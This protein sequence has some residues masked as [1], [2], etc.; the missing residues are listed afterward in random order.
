MAEG[1]RS[2][3]SFDPARYG[4]IPV[5]EL[6]RAAAR[7]WVGVDRRLIQSL[8]DRGAG[9]ASETLAFSREPH[10]SDPVGLEP[11]L[12][13]LFRHF[14]EPAALDFFVDAVR[15][16]PEEVGDDLVQA[17]LPF[18]EKALDP[19]LA[20]YDELGEERGGEVAFLLAGLGQRD[21]RVLEVLLERLEYDAADGAFLLG[22]YCDPAARPALEQMLA[23]VPVDA[24]ELRREISYALESIDNQI[25]SHALRYE[26]EPFDILAQYPE[27]DLPE[28]QILTEAE[29]IELLSSPDREIRGGAAYSFFNEE[30]SG[31]AR[32]ALLDI[33]R[34]DPDPEVRG[35]AWESLGDAVGEKSVREQMLAILRD[36]TRPVEERGGAAVGLYGVGGEAEVS[37]LLEALYQE[38]GHARA[39]ALEGMWRSLHKPFARFFP[40]HLNDEDPAIVEQALRGAGYFQ[41]STY[42]DKMASYFDH[43]DLREHA[44]FAYALA[45]PGETSRGRAQGMLRKIDAIAHLSRAEIRLV[46]FGIDE[47]LRLHGLKPVFDAEPEGEE[48][49]AAAAPVPPPEGKPGRNDPCPCGSGKKYKKCHGA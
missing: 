47:R 24:V 30:L 34:S 2:V 18:G 27:R 32:T 31:A 25:D 7:G 6:L 44:L 3:A 45:M 49:T 41:L 14:H 33:A 43:E 28:F 46:A 9:C 15:E 36:S 29:R 21:P 10:A 11:V 1:P 38:G 37:G 17:L 40:A 13:D 4:E 12:T 19:L 39:K 22:L 26:P 5:A 42:L 8:L 35:L 23:E 20:L 16:A 48:K